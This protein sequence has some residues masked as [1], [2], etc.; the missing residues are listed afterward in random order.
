MAN[1]EHVALLKQGAD[2]WK[3]WRGKNPGIRPDLKS[4][5]CRVI[6]GS[7]AMSGTVD[8]V[9]SSNSATRQWTRLTHRSPS[10]WMFRRFSGAAATRRLV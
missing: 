5:F 6:S 2:A 7:S 1:E 8:M 10:C 4:F 3:E 9:A